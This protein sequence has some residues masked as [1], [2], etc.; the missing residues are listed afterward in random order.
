MFF[1]LSRVV[2]VGEKVAQ[3]LVAVYSDDE[4]TAIMEDRRRHAELLKIKGVGEARLEKI[5][6]SWSKYR[7]VKLLSDLLAPYGITANLVMR[8]YN[9]FG[10]PSVDVI[11][12]NVYRLCEVR[13]IGFR[14]ADE[15]AL[16]L[17]VKPHDPLRIGAALQYVLE[18]LAEDQG[19]TL[20][21]AETA[22]SVAVKE[23]DCEHGRVMTGEVADVLAQL[24]ARG[25][26]V[27]YDESVA[28]AKYNFIEKKIYTILKKRASM[29]PFRILSPEKTEAYI[30]KAQQEMRIVFSP[31]QAEAIRMV[32][33][34]HRT[35]GI[36]GL[37][38]SGKS[39]LSKALINLLLERFNA[40]DVCCM[41][42]SG[43]AA[44]RIR[45][46]S[47]FNA[48]T[49]HSALGWK[50][51][52]FEFG[53]DKQLGYQ[54]VVVDE[55]SM[56]NSP[57]M[58]RVLE[59]VDR[60]ACLIFAGD[61]GQL[62]PIGSGDV[63]RN[64]L[65]SE[66]IPAARLTKIYRQSENSV[67][68]MFASD[69]RN[70]IVPEGYRDRSDYHDFGFVEKNLP[71]KYFSLPDEE[72]QPLRDKNTAE[73]LDYVSAKLRAVAPFLRDPIGDLQILSPIK[74]GPLGTAALNDLAQRILNPDV[75][76]EETL[77]IG[78]TLFQV[79]DKV[80]HNQNKDIEVLPGWTVD[81]LAKGLDG[82]QEPNT[83]RVFNGSL[84]MVL[85]IDIQNREIWVAYPE[86]F[87]ARYD[88]LMLMGGIL[89]LAYALTTHRVQGSEFRL[90]IL[91]I[92]SVHTMMLTA[93]WLYTAIT[94]ARQKCLVV[95]QKFMFE[96]C[97]RSL[98]ETARTTVLSRLVL[99]DK[100][101]S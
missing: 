44:D 101:K 13:G 47:G 1:F 61:P 35:I 2:K 25:D 19:T 58:L 66:L 23:L 9:H 11:R 16:H 80:I 87:I 99:M 4:L 36:A 69:I 41:A 74:K 81:D 60:D 21:T 55:S 68:A 38:G 57:L 43:I 86:G 14:R 56:I 75:P 95:G 6:Q 10:D 88:A 12:S 18:T 24:E 100:P 79:G 94:R 62:P 82:Q 33:A 83:R 48:Q 31:E 78:G 84:G 51:T 32:A 76:K 52:E 97:I 98:S 91:P 72:K 7:H 45:K 30:A 73:I 42:L 71:S 22:V 93:P 3:E 64:M 39:T 53:A 70:G 20:V 96:R 46:L 8:V 34:G 50:G 59:A 15:V 92:S 29:P 28:L 17:G 65:D 40:D 27:R 90:V 26:V 54:V 77:L 63:F 67:L 85:A 89:S 37:A 49:I 5:A